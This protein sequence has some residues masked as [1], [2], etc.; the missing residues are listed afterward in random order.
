MPRLPSLDIEY[1]TLYALK[2]FVDV[3]T[4]RMLRA[5]TILSYLWGPI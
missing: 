5:E 4:L 2:N 3:T 1:I